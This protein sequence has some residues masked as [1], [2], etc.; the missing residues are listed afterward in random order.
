MIKVNP[1]L[2]LS[3]LP[4][5]GPNNIVD[6]MVRERGYDLLSLD[7]TG[8]CILEMFSYSDFIK[9]TQNYRLLWPKNKEEKWWNSKNTWL[10]KNYISNLKEEII[11]KP[12]K[13]NNFLSSW[14]EKESFSKP[15]EIL[16]CYD[17]KRH[18]NLVVDGTNRLVALHLIEDEKLIKKLFS[19]NHVYMITFKTKKADILF[20]CDFLHFEKE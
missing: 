10:V 4:F 14:K 5:I 8:E 20:P 7:I 16:V 1:E 17:L 3:R 9:I 13:V 2:F 18:L 6:L 15:I 12:T 19:S 11:S